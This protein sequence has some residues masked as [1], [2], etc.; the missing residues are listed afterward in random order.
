MTTTSEAKANLS[1]RSF[2]SLQMAHTPVHTCIRKAKTHTHIHTQTHTQPHTHTQTHPHTHKHTQ[3][4]THNSISI[5][6]SPAFP[7]STSLAY[8]S[9]WKKLTY[10]V[11]RSFNSVAFLRSP[12]FVSFCDSISISFQLYLHLISRSH[13]SPAAAMCVCACHLERCKM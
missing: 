10:R 8:V 13:K 11:I 6:V 1:E 7:I 9:F 2:T 12:P 4:H 5:F 3:T